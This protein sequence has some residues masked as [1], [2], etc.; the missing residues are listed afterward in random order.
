MKKLLF[1]WLAVLVFLLVGCG[2]HVDSP[3]GTWQLELAAD[4][5]G[6][7]LEEWTD[8]TCTLTGDGNLTFSGDFETTGT[9]TTQTVDS[10]TLRLE[11]ATEDGSAWVGTYGVRS[12]QDGSTTPVLLLSCDNY[13]LS[14][15]S[16]E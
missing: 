10:E 2:A 6:E 12:Y 16:E 5:R 1:S 3:V 9:Y 7:P 4:G 14:F 11:A 15:L 13:I 8:I